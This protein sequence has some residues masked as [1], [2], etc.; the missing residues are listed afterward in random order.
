MGRVCTPGEGIE[1]ELDTRDAARRLLRHEE[2]CPRELVIRVTAVLRPFHAELLAN[3]TKFV[4]FRKIL[5]S[6][7]RSAERS[8]TL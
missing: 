2:M 8:L 4:R 1:D 5:K 7:T 3:S 6:G